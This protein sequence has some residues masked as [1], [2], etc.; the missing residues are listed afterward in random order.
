M[1]TRRVNLDDGAVE[2][3]KTILNEP[4]LSKA[5][6][7]SISFT[8]ST[9]ENMSRGVVVYSNK[10]DGSQKFWL[11]SDEEIGRLFKYFQNRKDGDVKDKVDTVAK[12]LGIVNF[13]LENVK[14]EN[15]ITVSVDPSGKMNFE[16]N[17]PDKNKS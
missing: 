13:L 8:V 2:E 14:K 16:I 4:T 5:L 7:K 9:L 15:S 1:T 12:C 17:S 6:L 11:I 10:S 3:L